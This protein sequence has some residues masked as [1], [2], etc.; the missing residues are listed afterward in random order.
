MSIK[1]WPENER[2]REKLLMRGEN[3]LSDAELLA[4]ILQTGT[5]EKNALDLSRELLQYFGSLQELLNCDL[6]TF[7]QFKGLNKAKF[8]LL[9]TILEI[10]RRY[11]FE[12]A[13]K[14]I[15]L[16]NSNDTRNYLL[17]KLS[18][19]E[20]EVF[21]CLFLNNKNQ[22]IK[23]KELF[24]GSIDRAEVYPRE[25]MKAALKYNATSIIISHNHTSGD[26]TP[27]NAD[28]K[29]TQHL[30]HVLSLI[31]INLLDHIIVGKGVARSW[32]IV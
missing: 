18:Y 6:E 5:K 1:T 9:K 4:I 14:T 23:Y 28:I 10:N 8:A 20:Q 22:I 29:L 24:Y 21:A 11:F 17:S 27:S 13:K 25:I 31:N 32:E 30:K 7:C 15:A 26:P 16:K 12:K 19:R 3:A 2:P